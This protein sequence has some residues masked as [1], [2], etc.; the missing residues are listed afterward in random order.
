M[1]ALVAFFTSCRK[2]TVE[3]QVP[4]ISLMQ[5]ASYMQAVPVGFSDSILPR[6]VVKI[7]TLLPIDSL[8]FEYRCVYYNGSMGDVV[9]PRNDFALVRREEF[10]LDSSQILTFVGK[11][12]FRRY[13]MYPIIGLP[14]A[15]PNTIWVRAKATYTINGI[16]RQKEP[17]NFNP[18]SGTP[19][20]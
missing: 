16:T 7:N 12:S 15:L 18:L 19:W 17:D 14:A 4:H 20:L 8:N 5:K 6:Y 1:I 13:I 10:I 9:I 3:L 11:R 2:E